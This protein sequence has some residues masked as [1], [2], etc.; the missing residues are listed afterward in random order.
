MLVR[1]TN[2]SSLRLLPG[3]KVRHLLEDFLQRIEHY[4]HA[5]DFPAIKGSSYLSVH[6]Q[7]GTVSIRLL[8]CTAHAM[9]AGI[10]ERWPAQRTD[11]ARFYHKFWPATPGVVGPKTFKPEYDHIHW[12]QGKHAK[13]LF[14]QLRG[15]HRLPTGGCS[16]SQLN[17]TR[18]ASTGCAWWWPVF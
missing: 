2:L 7:F 10:P 3:T 4:G 16:L 8:V 5:R 17:Q 18:T 6:L 9:H 14:S 15:P 13:A 11:L 1:P 12:E